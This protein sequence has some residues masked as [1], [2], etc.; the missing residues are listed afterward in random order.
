MITVSDLTIA[1]IESLAKA[2]GTL[3]F[4]RSE[5]IKKDDEIKELKEKIF[6]LEKIIK[7]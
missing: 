3:S 6:N 4:M 5:L 2:I 1:T 7:T